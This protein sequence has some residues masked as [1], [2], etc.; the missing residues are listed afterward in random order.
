MP[1]SWETAKLENVKVGDNKISLNYKKTKQGY[2]FE[3][4]V[5]NPNWIIDFKPKENEVLKSTT[6]LSSTH[7]IYKVTSGI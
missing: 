1:Q 2:S 7:K 4:E 6:S 5:D 3:I